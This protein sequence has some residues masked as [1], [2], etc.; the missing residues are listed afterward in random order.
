MQKGEQQH[1]SLG[2]GDETAQDWE[3][4]LREG[5]LEKDEGLLNAP[6]VRDDGRQQERHRRIAKLD[7]A[8]SKRIV[9]RLRAGGVW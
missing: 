7:V 2:V 4:C 1:F 9:I 3:A 6:R 8:S 5:R